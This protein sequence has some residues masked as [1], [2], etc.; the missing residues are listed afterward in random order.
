[1]SNPS[2]NDLLFI[3]KNDSKLIIKEILKKMSES[4]IDNS[5]NF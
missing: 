5:I 2:V 3:C 4:N 1:M